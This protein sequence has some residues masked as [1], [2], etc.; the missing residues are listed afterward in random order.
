MSS[1]D[2][3]LQ[4]HLQTCS[5]MVLQCISKLVQSWLPSASLSFPNLGLQLHLRT[6]LVIAFRY[7][8]KSTSAQSGETVELV[9]LP[10]EICQEEKFWREECRKKVCRD[11]RVPGDEEPHL[12][13]ESMNAR[14]EC[15]GPRAGKDRLC[16]I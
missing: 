4:V 2:P 16:I 6:Y 1:R 11:G 9:Q 12:V 14:Q 8:S 10:K 15:L 5:I 7:I 13:C 3:S